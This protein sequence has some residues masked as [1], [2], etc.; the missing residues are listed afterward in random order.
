V[1]VAIFQTRPNNCITFKKDIAG[2]EK[3]ASFK[4][5]SQ[6]KWVDFLYTY[7]TAAASLLLIAAVT[8]TLIIIIRRKFKHSRILVY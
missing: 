5:C 6:N 2:Y 1:Q 3:I 4:F 7:W 8:C